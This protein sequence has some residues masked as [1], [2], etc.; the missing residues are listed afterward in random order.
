MHNI[1]ILQVLMEVCAN[2][3]LNQQLNC[4][5]IVRQKSSIVW[6]VSAWS[7]WASCVARKYTQT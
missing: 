6:M 7:K 1:I 5:Q 3:F 2:F 4:I